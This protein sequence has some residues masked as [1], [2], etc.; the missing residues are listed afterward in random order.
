MAE[1]ITFLLAERIGRIQAR[2]LVTEACAR[3][4]T[5]GRSLRA[6]LESDPRIELTPEELD[7]AFDPTGYLGSAE[8]FVERALDLYRQRGGMR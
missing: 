2:E 3:A 7:A 1:R 8:A 6:E 4:V 5:G